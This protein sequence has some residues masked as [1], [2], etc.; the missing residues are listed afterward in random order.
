MTPESFL[1]YIPVVVITAIVVAILWTANYLIRRNLTGELSVRKQSLMLCLSGAGLLL[2]IFSAPISETSRGQILSLL[3]IV[4]TAVI[5]LSST[6]FVA[7]IMAGLMLRAV[8]SFRPGDFIRC[9]EY[10]GR[11]TERGLFH[12]EIQT[13][14]RDLATVP[15][16]FLVTNPLTVVL[17]S[18]TIISAEL[19][20]GYDVSHVAAEELLK[21]AAIAAGLSDAFVLVGELGDFSVSYRVGGFS[22][23]VSRLLT[24]KSNLRK[25]ILA[26]LH[27][28]RVEIVSPNFMNQRVLSR[29]E[30]VIPTPYREPAATAAGEEVSPE[31]VIF[32]KADNAVER[33]TIKA[34]IATRKAEIEALAEQKKA[35]PEQAETFA[36]A[37]ARLELEVE[38]LSRQLAEEDL[39]TQ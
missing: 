7:N 3:G 37:K 38:A 16:L 26:T 30:R 24:V 21:E 4:I 20:L 32:D 6:T 25:N 8:N 17:E 18:G 1:P 11:V 39:E 36:A 13:P 34:E 22:E 12:T 23:D 35:A 15:N 28:N 27:A 10:F 29:E 19:S 5:A 9:Q 14:D 33:E 31:E 2:I